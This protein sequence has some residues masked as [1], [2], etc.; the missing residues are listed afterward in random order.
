MTK[1]GYYFQKMLLDDLCQRCGDWASLIAVCDYD[2]QRVLHEWCETCL[3]QEMEEWH[4][5]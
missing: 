3:S 1:P 5:R 2:T 4:E